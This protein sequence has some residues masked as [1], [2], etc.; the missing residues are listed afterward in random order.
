MVSVKKY[1]GRPTTKHVTITL[2]VS[3]S[4]SSDKSKR[5]LIVTWGERERFVFNYRSS[6]K[7]GH[8]KGICE[9]IPEGVVAHVDGN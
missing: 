4:S 7:Y 2:T 6:G 5:V 8:R 1:E 9:I 3:P